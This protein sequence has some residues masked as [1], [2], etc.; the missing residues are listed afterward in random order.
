MDNSWRKSGRVRR[1]PVPARTPPRTAR[2]LLRFL[3]VDCGI[4]HYR[5]ESN[6][7]EICMHEMMSVVHRL[8]YR[9]RNCSTFPSFIY[10][11]GFWVTKVVYCF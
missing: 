11:L 1:S 6:M 8:V 4:K 2:A 5:E 9:T 3:Y 10:H 7:R